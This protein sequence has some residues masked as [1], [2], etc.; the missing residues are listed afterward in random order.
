MPGQF[1]FPVAERFQSSWNVGP[2]L[3]RQGFEEANDL[4]NLAVGKTEGGHAGVE[5]AA[6]T[7]A[8][9]TP[10]IHGRVSEKTR[11][12]IRVH[13]SALADQRRRK[14]LL[15]VRILIAGHPGKVRLL[16]GPHLMASHAVVTLHQPPAFPNILS[17]VAGRVEEMFGQGG[18]DAPQQKG[19][20]ARDFLVSQ[21][22]IGH[23]ELFHGGLDLALVEDGRVFQLALEEALVVVPAVMLGLVGQQG[24]VQPLD[25]FAALAGQLRSDAP[26][27][28]EACDFV[29]TRA[30]EV[31]DPHRSFARERRIVQV[32]GL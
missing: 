16:S 3:S 8:V 2:I 20:Q 22:E 7:V 21:L 6:H 1:E 29:A 32:V 18:V 23:P 5:I 30:A 28:L 14:L 9:A 11:Q 26:F 17:P 19:G 25:G 4:L 10:G 12:P 24:E 15:P 31:L 13:P 27:L